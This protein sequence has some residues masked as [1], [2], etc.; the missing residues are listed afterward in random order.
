MVREII[1]QMIQDFHRQEPDQ[2]VKRDFEFF[3]V[4]KKAMVC[5]GVR[6]CG[7]STLMSQRINDLVKKG[8]KKENI[9]GV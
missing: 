2:F 7:K 3:P 4:D 5:V 9:R 8:T 6:R 1:K